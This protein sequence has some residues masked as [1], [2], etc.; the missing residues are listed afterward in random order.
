MRQAKVGAEQVKEAINTLCSQGLLGDQGVWMRE[1][2][3]DAEHE[4]ASGPVE[5]GAENP[6]ED[7]EPAAKKPKKRHGPQVHTY[8]KQPWSEVAKDN[9]KVTFAASLY[10]ARQHFP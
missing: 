3:A 8:A 2:L 1:P 4:E 10:L 5:E 7:G 9:V 6:A